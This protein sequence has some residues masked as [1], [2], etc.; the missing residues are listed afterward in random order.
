MHHL[1][2]RYGRIALK[3]A[4][5]QAIEIGRMPGQRSLD[6][7]PRH[8]KEMRAIALLK[9]PLVVE[10]RQCQWI[11]PAIFV[12]NLEVAV[13]DARLW[14]GRKRILDSRQR[15]RLER[16]ACCGADHDLGF[17]PR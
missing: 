13:D 6:G 16:D 15:V 2:G 4:V 8:G 14:N 9:H 5:E 17:A 10:R 7:G 3:L 12:A 11:M 1:P